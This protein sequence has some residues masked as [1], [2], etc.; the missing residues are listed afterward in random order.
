[1]H[2]L[3]DDE[4]KAF[5]GILLHAG[6]HRNIQ[7]FIPTDDAQADFG[8]CYSRLKRLSTAPEMVCDQ[9]HKSLNQAPDEAVYSTLCV[10]QDSLKESRYRF[11]QERD[12]YEPERVVQTQAWIDQFAET[13]ERLKAASPTEFKHHLYC[14]HL[15]LGEETV[16]VFRLHGVELDV[17]ETELHMAHID[18]IMTRIHITQDGTVPPRNH[19]H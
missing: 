6:Q 19:L 4:A 11:G 18:Q 12:Q 2:M 7:V 5:S 1:M 15:N 9:I 14:H 3:Y 10:L 17:F 13:V 16:A 8:A